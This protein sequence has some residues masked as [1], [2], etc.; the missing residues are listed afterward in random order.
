MGDGTR[1]S[2][3]LYDRPP[4]TLWFGAPLVVAH[5]RAPTLIV[6]TSSTYAAE[7]GEQQTTADHRLSG[8]GIAALCVV[9]LAL[10]ARIPT[11]G[12]QSFWTDEAATLNVLHHSFTGM[13]SAIASQESTPPLYYVLTWLWTHLFGYSEFAVRFPSAVAGIGL[14][15][16]VYRAGLELGGPR[17]G[18]LAGMLTA[19]N[20]LLVWYSQEARSYSL[21]AML[22][23]WSFYLVV[24][25][26]DDEAH[27]KRWL[28]R[29]AVVAALALCT[30][31]FAIFVVVPEALWL[32]FRR[33]RLARLQLIFVLVVG[34]ALLPLALH[35]RASGRTDWITGTPLR[36]RFALIPKEFVTGLSAPHQTILAATGLLVAAVALGF[37]VRDRKAVKAESLLATGTLLG[38]PIAMVVL[39]LAGVDLVL[40]RNAIGLVPIG[41]L[42]VACGLARLAEDISGV[43]ATV[44][45]AVLVAVGAF[46]I[47][48]VDSNARYQ[49]P[50]WR[51]AGRVLT[52]SGT[53]QL[54]VLEPASAQLPLG[55]YV[56]LEHLGA[57]RHALVRQVAVL[58]FL[59]TVQGGPAQL[60]APRLPRGFRLQSVSA[61]PELRLTRYVSARPHAI[62]IHFPRSATFVIPKPG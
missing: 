10:V 27:A 38:A 61:W 11:L 36:T 33:G 4:F 54:L 32:V 2:R 60:A 6:S 40:T 50:D 41:L 34:L 39:A 43:A 57:R 53:T 18:L 59:L 37:L 48:S 20:P 31:Y 21:V 49:R 17:V 23:A 45:T 56:R 15:W 1:G 25:C 24:R 42:A 14:V 52:R 8:T 16:I 46:A 19:V 51:A 29:W 9:S 13:F 55:V 5:P 7:A 58:Q 3:R 62:S 26:G 28:W 47:V 44:L 35:Q 22:C 12:Q 30:H